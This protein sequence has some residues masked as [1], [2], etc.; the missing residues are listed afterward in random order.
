MES[1]PL[2]QYRKMVQNGEL[3]ADPAQLLAVEKLQLLANRLASSE[4][5][6]KTDIF[7]FFTR[8][9]GA[10]PEGLYMFGGVGR[11]K[12][13]LM[14]LF[15]ETVP[16]P[17]KRR[18]HFHEFMAD[19]HEHLDRARHTIDGDPIPFVAREIALHSCLSCPRYGL[20]LRNWRWPIARHHDYKRLR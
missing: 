3:K 9:G 7:S 6:K 14:D 8:K 12:T 10:V 2:R 13:M 15:F 11:G 5:P 17:A 4:P 18:V 16:F 1:G 19:V 20:C